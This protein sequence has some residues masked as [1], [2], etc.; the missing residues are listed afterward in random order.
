MIDQLKQIFKIANKFKNIKF[1]LIFC[2][3]SNNQSEKHNK[4]INSKDVT[5][6]TISIILTI[7]I[8]FLHS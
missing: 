3:S 7:N 8:I 2:I 6:K 4:I 5:I 1:A